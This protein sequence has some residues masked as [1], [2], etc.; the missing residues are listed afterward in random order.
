MQRQGAMAALF[1]VGNVHL[2][3]AAL[4]PDAASDALVP[5]STSRK[6]T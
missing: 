3:C 5:C 1:V 4:P 2:L 6:M